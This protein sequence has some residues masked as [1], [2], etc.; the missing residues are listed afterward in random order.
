MRNR[1][2]RH[3]G[4]LKGH[5]SVMY[6]YVYSS[7]CTFIHKKLTLTA[8]EA[9]AARQQC[10]SAVLQYGE[11]GELSSLPELRGQQA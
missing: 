4:E 7:Q 10:T 5:Y 2:P 11:Q 9:E 1:L 8:Y 3:I 6:E